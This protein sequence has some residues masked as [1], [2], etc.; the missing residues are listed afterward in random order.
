[1]FYSDFILTLHTPRFR[2]KIIHVREDVVLEINGKK[3]RLKDF[4][5][6]ALKGTVVG[7]IKSLNLE[8]DPKEIRITIVLDDENSG[9]SRVQGST[10]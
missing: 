7:F 1:M 6:R 9:D 2:V 4:P 8:E 10:G 5:M 3:I